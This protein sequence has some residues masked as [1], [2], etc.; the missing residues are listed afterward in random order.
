VKKVKK[1]KK[2]KIVK[3]VKIDIDKKK[4]GQVGITNNKERDLSYNK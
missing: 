2:V 1:V 3:I 4:E